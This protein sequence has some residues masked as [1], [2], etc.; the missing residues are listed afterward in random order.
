MFKEER[1]KAVRIIMVCVFC[2]LLGFFLL[3]FMSIKEAPVL[4]NT[5]YIIS[6]EALMAASVIAIGFTLRKLYRMKKKEKR[7]KSGSKVVF[8][9]EREGRRHR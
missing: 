1:K 7:K 9:D 4:G 8:L 3:D 5:F 6:G 2:F